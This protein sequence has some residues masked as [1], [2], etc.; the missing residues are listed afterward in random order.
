MKRNLIMKKRVISDTLEEQVECT[1]EYDS[2][3]N[4]IKDIY[5]AYYGNGEARL[6]T[7]YKYIYPA[8]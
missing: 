1:F 5:Y 4:L 7:E 2:E 3:E 6:V 8:K